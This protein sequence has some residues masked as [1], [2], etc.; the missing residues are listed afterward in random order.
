M[1]KNLLSALMKLDVDIVSMSSMCTALVDMQ[2]K[3]T[4]QRLLSALP[5]L[6][7]RV[8]TVQG[9]KTSSPTLVNG[10]IGVS[11]S[12]GKSAIFWV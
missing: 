1:Q 9:P 4:A 6:V 11:L 3:S 10:G 7:R 8:V 2:V 12:T 5:P